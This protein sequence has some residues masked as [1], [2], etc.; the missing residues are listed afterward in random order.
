[1]LQQEVDFKSVDC[2]C[3]CKIRCGC[4]SEKGNIGSLIHS[5]LKAIIQILHQ[6]SIRIRLDDE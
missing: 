1:M 2:L 6:V 4:G 3:I 5:Y